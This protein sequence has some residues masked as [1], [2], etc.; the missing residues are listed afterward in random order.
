MTY[1]ETDGVC[2]WAK[3]LQCLFRLNGIRLLAV[4]LSKTIKSKKLMLISYPANIN[5][6]V[7]EKT[8]VSL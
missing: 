7:K 5:R 3:L 8:L 1:Y 6:K 2:T 4:E